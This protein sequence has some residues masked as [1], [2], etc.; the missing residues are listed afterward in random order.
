MLNKIIIVIIFSQFILGQK[1]QSKSPYTQT[2]K[3]YFDTTKKIMCEVD[4]SY[5]FIKESPHRIN[6]LIADPKFIVILRKP[7]ERALSHYYMS[8]YRGYET[9]SFVDAL[10]MEKNRLKNSQYK[11]EKYY[12]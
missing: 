8:Y 3:V 6:E 12:T 2:N 10:D 7:I 4:P 1:A 11:K 5:L 9:L